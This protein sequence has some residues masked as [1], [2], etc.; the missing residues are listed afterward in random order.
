M[1][2]FNTFNSQ[3]RAVLI[4]DGDGVCV[5]VADK[6]V[7]LHY[8]NIPG[9]SQN[10]SYTGLS[11]AGKVIS[12]STYPCGAICGIGYN[13]NAQ[14]AIFGNRSGDDFLPRYAERI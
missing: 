11:P 3:L 4:T 1:Y 13:I 2:K 6:I 10:K 7:G 5:V 9:T 8:F 12:G 14:S